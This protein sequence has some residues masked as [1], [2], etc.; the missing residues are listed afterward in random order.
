M[1]KRNAF[2]IQQNSLSPEKL[3]SNIK[4]KTDRVVLSLVF[5]QVEIG[6]FAALL[7]ATIVLVGLYHVVNTAILF[8]WYVTFWLITIM[9][10]TLIK[11]YFSRIILEDNIYFWRR[12][13]IIGT[14]LVGLCWGLLG[15]LLLPANND[16][17]LTFVV[18]ILA[19]VTASAIPLYSAILSSAISFLIVTIVPLTIRLFLFDTKIYFLFGCASLIYLTVLIL[20]SLKNHNTILQSVGLQFE[21]DALLQ[22]LSNAKQLL[23]VTNQKLAHAAKHDP[24]TDLANRN[25]FELSFKKA[26]KK[27]QQE[28][29]IVGLFY[30][31]IDNFKEINDAY[32]HHIGD[33]L[34][35]KIVERIKRKL[36]TN[37]TPAR[38]G[39][40]EITII[41]EDADVEIMKHVAKQLCDIIADPFEINEYNI[42]TSLSIGISV[43]PVDGRDFEILLKNADK[44]MYY[45]KNK[46]GNNFHFYTDVLTMKTLLQNTLFNSE[47]RL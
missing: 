27:A 39:G 20:L 31:D 36:P 7:C 13:F 4:E 29:K 34:L 12:L 24:L 3:A 15:S 11:T 41:L 21:N 42:L 2:F 26:I 17:L 8:T 45:V 28:K 25:L 19:G 38:L 23:E 46:G 16:A 37:A 5:R 43:Y 18:L 32:G 10:F 1:K 35:Q 9:R 40:D 22:N 14:I 6:S 30:L 44:A 33:Q 47:T